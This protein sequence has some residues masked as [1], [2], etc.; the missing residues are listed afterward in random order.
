MIRI[1]VAFFILIYIVSFVGAKTTFFDNPGDA[2]IFGFEAEE[3]SST[4][5]NPVSSGA[6][7]STE[8]G[9][10]FKFDND[11]ENSSVDSL[12]SEDELPNEP[13]AWLESVSFGIFPFAILICVSVFVLGLVY[14]LLKRFR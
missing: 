14:F 5:S 10:F 4:G 8:P 13:I 7:E 3:S 12:V 6:Q 11:E 9:G 1:I 2:F